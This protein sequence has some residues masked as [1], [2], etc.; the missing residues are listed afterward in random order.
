MADLLVV[1]YGF[2]QNPAQENPGGGLF[3]PIQ[4]K[5]RSITRGY[6][7]ELIVLVPHRYL[8]LSIG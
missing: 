3:D 6:S 4:A 7:Y 8:S 2:R 1:F 5:A